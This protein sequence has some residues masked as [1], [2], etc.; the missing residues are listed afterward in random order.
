MTQQNKR[1]YFLQRKFNLNALNNNMCATV[2]LNTVFLHMPCF[3]NALPFNF[4]L[5]DGKLC[6]GKTYLFS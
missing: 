4:S 6:Y 3:L 5:S 1:K 2:P